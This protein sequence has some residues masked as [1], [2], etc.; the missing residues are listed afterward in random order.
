MGAPDA[1]ISQKLP[2]FFVLV[3]TTSNFPRCWTLVRPPMVYYVEYNVLQR[4][5]GLWGPIW[6]HT[7]TSSMARRPAY[8]G[9][10]GRIWS[11]P[12]WRGG[13][14]VGAHMVI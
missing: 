3:A 13:Q 2:C 12:L 9:S 5:T 4:A 7:V 8:W 14:P 6:S 10:Y 11:L 1:K